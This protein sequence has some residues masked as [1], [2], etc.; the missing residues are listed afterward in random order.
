MKSVCA[1]AVVPLGLACVLLSVPRPVLAQAS[2]L[3]AAYSFDQGSGGT[4]ADVSGNGN[5]GTIQSATWTPSGKF[6]SALAFNGSSARVQIPDANV[7]DLTTGVTL[8]AWVYPT[9][10]QADW[11]TVVQKQAD[12]YLLSA[13]NSTGNLRPACGATF[14]SGGVTAASTSAIP[15][16]TWTHLA[17]SYDGAAVRLYVNGTQVASTARTG[18]IVP[19]A[20]PLWI[21]GNSPYGEYFNGRI[22]EVRVWRVARTAAQIATDMNTSVGTP[23]TTPPSA[24]GALGATAIS[25][26]RVDLAWTAATDD[27]GIGSYEVER[28]AGASCS[29][30][31]LL[32]A[33]TALA[34]S[35]TTALASTSYSYRVRAR[36]T[37]TNPG[38]YTN[39]ATA[40]TPA[41]PDLPPSAP[42]GLTAAAP[43][44]TRVDLAWTAATDDRGIAQYEIERCTG[45]S[46]SSF[47]PLTTTTAT[48]FPDT[49]VSAST[50]Y[51]YRVRARDTGNNA[52]PYSGT[53]TAVTPAAPDTTPPTAPSALAATAASSLRVDLAW[54]AASDAVGVARYRIERCAGASCT[55]F[56]E[57]G[58]STVT[59]Y[60]DATVSASTT[61]QYRA[62]AEDAAGNRGPYS[63]TAPVTTPAPPVSTGLVAAYGFDE[64]AGASSADATGLGHTL[65][66]GG[67]AW[68]TGGKN[69]SALSFNGTSAR[70]TV[71]DANDLDLTGAMT[72]E[73]W[74][75]PNAVSSGWRTILHKETDRFYLFASSSVSGPATGGTF[76][77]SNVNA[78][79]GAGL[80]AVTWT[81]LAGTYDGTTVKVYVNGVLA[82][83]APASGSIGVS[84]SPLSIGGTAAYGEYFN[85]RID[86]V[87][88]YNRALSAA[89]IQQDMAT[90]VP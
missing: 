61:Y 13:G 82:G 55:G 3:V 46:C 40:V 28:C 45:P 50:S 85:G 10:N 78:F 64:G 74:V 17:M 65:A 68:T 8:E 7:L 11:R 69:G 22:D 49:G 84:G 31:S 16:N 37:S 73:A 44:P 26:T 33:T 36:D 23:D 72:L 27:R 67:A 20:S 60:A 51:S 1:R 42:G 81:H 62:L 53:A 30:F 43:Q 58:T 66:V 29:S 5:T 75:Y 12:S 18:S 88:I 19:T 2:D 14:S 79:G 57:I 89:E 80:A 25:A 15:T 6:G 86:D 48:S 56:A 63:N 34:F 77:S 41:A 4:V 38:P 9:A 35:D 24:P 90:P 32:T 83:S 52:G 47:A 87:R 70:A 59:S 71:A 39:V 54:T 21:G 76:G